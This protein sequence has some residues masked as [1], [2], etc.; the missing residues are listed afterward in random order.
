[1]TRAENGSPPWATWA[2]SASTSPR[3]RPRT[4]PCPHPRADLTDP[5]YKGEIVMPDPASSGTGYL[6]VAAIVRGGGED[7]WQL[8]TDLDKN[9]AQYTSSGSKPCKMARAG[10]YAIGASFSFVAMQSIEAGFPI[11]MVI[12]S[13]YAGYE[14]EASGLLAS[15]DNKEDAKRFL[16]WSLGA[17]A[18]DVYSQFKAIV[19]VPGATRTPAADAAGLPSNLADVL[20][21]V[22]FAASAASRGETLTRWK[23]ITS[24]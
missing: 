15:S 10:E 13:D 17:D 14:L 24:D 21:P 22:D 16:D 8:I 7:G 23:E 12:P 6:Q 2:R 18:A 20:F 1:M 4:C 19:T 3:W 11:A 5:V 9:I